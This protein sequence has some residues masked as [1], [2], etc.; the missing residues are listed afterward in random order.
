MGSSS[1]FEGF[2]ADFFVVFV[3]PAARVVTRF[4]GAAFLAADLRCTADFVRLAAFFVVRLAVFFAARSA[5]FFAGFFAV[6]VAVFFEPLF[7]F[8][9][10]CLLPAFFVVAFFVPAF[11][12]REA[13]FARLGLADRVCAWCC[14]AWR[15]S[16]SA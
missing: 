9:A 3:G 6:R 4:F 12:A 2:R 13:G 16:T 14:V 7:F 15:P 1:A 10:T 11:F 5:T 8:A